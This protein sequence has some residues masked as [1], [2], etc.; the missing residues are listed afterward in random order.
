AARNA[1]AGL[2]PDA[3]F[4][5]FLA[6][7]READ[8]SEANRFE[9][10]LINLLRRRTAAD[11]E[12]LLK[13]AS[14]HVRRAALDALSQMGGPES[15]DKI[16]SLLRDEIPRVRGTAISTLQARKAVAHASL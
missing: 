12:A 11:A 1:V 7:T 2:D 10:H 6:A 5:E 4:P 15:I 13:D 14:F 16:V 8:E 3:A 9:A